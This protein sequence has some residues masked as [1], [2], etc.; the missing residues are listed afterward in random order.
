[1]RVDARLT[2]R[3]CSC[4]ALDGLQPSVGEPL[5]EVVGFRGEL[6]DEGVQSE[7]VG[8]QVEHHLHGRGC[9]VGEIVPVLDREPRGLDD[10]AQLVRGDQVADSGV[11][12]PREWVGRVAV[13]AGGDVPDGESPPLTSTRRASQ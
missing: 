1:M 13:F 9:L 12:G 7:R 4:D 10:R 8:W 5:G 2:R 6:G 11:V 3:H